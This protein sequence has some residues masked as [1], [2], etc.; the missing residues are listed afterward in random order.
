[1]PVV[2]QLI[3]ELPANPLLFLAIVPAGFVLICLL[4]YFKVHSDLRRY[5]GPILAKFTDAWI[6]WA[7]SQNRWADTVDRLHKE[8]GKPSFSLIQ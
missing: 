1:M 3:A 2:Q 8:H 7:I 6:F 5:P 4:D